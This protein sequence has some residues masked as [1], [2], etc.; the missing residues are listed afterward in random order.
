MNRP[1]LLALVMALGA[2]S[3][4]LDWREARPEG[5]DVQLMF[6]C[7]PELHQRA[8]AHMGLARCEAAGL[9][10]SLSWAEVPDPTLANAA[11]GKMRESLAAKLG[12]PAGPPQAFRAEGMTPS[13]EALSQ[14]VG[15][16]RPA[17]L[18]VFAKGAK[19][20]QAVMSGAHADPTAW[21]SFAGSIRILDAA[22]S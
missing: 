14:Q 15:G 11:L 9:E 22:R 13:P 8:D 10:F 18:A 16:S 17:Q 12:G 19:V 2:C 3:P 20:Y 1:L 7:K 5:A 6:P 21:E 4:A